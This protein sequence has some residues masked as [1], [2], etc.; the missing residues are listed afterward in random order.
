MIKL[1]K[2][3]IAPTTLPKNISDTDIFYSCLSVLTKQ[4]SE[5]L[6]QSILPLTYR[7]MEEYP[8][9]PLIYLHVI[10]HEPI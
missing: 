8:N 4:I 1:P 9:A 6:K 5:V 10:L 7:Q 2:I 3:L